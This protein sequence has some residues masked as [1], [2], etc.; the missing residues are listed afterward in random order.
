MKKI[1]I[2]LAALLILSMPVGVFAATSDSSAAASI[3]G[4]CGAGIA[5]LNLTEQQ[6]TDLDESFDKM[7]EVRKESINKMA[8]NGLMTKEQEDLAL[9]RLDQMKEFHEENGYGYGMGMMGGNGRGRGMMESNGYG[10]GM[11]GSYN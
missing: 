7:M 5:L 11:M 4:F 10:R 3:R 9:K 1:F 2:I 8:Q 6:K